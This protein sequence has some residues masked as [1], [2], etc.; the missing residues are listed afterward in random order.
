MSDEGASFGTWLRQRRRALDLTQ[1]ELARHVG[2]SEIMVRKLEADEARPSKQVA[3]LLAQALGVPGDERAGFVRFARAEPGAV[4]P[5]MPPETENDLPWRLRKAG[6]RGSPASPPS[7]SKPADSHPTNLTMP[8]T[9]LV[10]RAQAVARV[11]ALLL[12][13]DVRLLTLVGPPG[14]G[15]TRLGV[16]AGLQL[17]RSE[18]ERSDH[19]RAERGR[20][21]AHGGGPGRAVAGQA[22]IADLGQ[23]RAPPARGSPHQYAPGR[24]PRP[25]DNRYQPGSSSPQQRAAVPGSAA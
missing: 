22:A 24:L 16:Q 11:K 18:P 14:I 21:P 3:E 12:D 25:E 10:G 23:F 9:S 7:T 13:E 8:G 4:Q 6:S 15:K 20:K 2:C 17:S 1:K 5:S 19:P